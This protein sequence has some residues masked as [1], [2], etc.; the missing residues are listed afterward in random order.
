MFG[1]PEPN[2]WRKAD[3]S[4]LSQFELKNLHGGSI[5]IHP[6][7]NTGMSKVFVMDELNKLWAVIIPNSTLKELKEALL[8]IGYSL[9]AA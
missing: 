8:A 3:G 5:V 2:M 6:K 7:K 4:S 9:A 1:Q